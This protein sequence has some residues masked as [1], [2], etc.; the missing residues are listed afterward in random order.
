MGSDSRVLF[1]DFFLLEL[2]LSY[3]CF[4]SLKLWCRL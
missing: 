4:T 3:S 2:H 1:S